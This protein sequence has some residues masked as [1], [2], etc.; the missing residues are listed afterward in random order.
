M[1]FYRYYGYIYGEHVAGLVIA[2]NKIEA[3]QLL[4]QT[5]SDYN[6]WSDKTIEEEK[7]NENGVCEIYYG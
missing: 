5:Y 4:K 6:S 7:F 1:K 2:K 3:K